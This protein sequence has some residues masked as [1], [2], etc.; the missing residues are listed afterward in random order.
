MSYLLSG[1]D[2]NVILLRQRKQCLLSAPMKQ[3]EGLHEG[4]QRERELLLKKI[5][6]TRRLLFAT[7]DERMIEGMTELLHALEAE[8]RELSRVGWWPSVIENLLSRSR[9]GIDRSG[10]CTTP[11]IT[12][13]DGPCR[14]RP[15]PD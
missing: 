3:I 12:T 14:S 6:Q 11:S 1:T 9:S 5:E 4:S 2:D 8:L 13:P 15:F 7:T 10:T